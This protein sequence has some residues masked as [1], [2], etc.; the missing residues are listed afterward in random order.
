MATLCSH[1]ALFGF[2]REEPAC[3]KCPAAVDMFV[4]IAAGEGSGR[5]PPREVVRRKNTNG[6]EER[7]A[8]PVSAAVC[9]ACGPPEYTPVVPE[10]P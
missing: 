3:N 7:R 4:Y 10:P 2:G 8:H 1:V 5:L 6:L 9:F